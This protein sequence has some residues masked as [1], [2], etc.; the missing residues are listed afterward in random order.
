MFLLFFFS[1]QVWL[2]CF[3]PALEGRSRVSW[4]RVLP[5]SPSHGQASNE[6]K[7]KKE[8][9]LIQK[10]RGK[11]INRSAIDRV[12]GCCNPNQ[13]VLSTGAKNYSDEKF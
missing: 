10:K 3:L 8:S 9:F 11:T 5:T 1:D 2:P 7:K 12:L 6:R 4:S 13:L